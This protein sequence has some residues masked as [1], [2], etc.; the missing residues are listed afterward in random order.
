MLRRLE[1]RP[2]RC[3]N[4]D[5]SPDRRDPRSPLTIPSAR[6]RPGPEPVLPQPGVLPHTAAALGIQA[7]EALD[8]AH[9]L[10]IV[11]RDIK[12]ANLLLDV[13]GNLWITDFGLARL[14]DDAGLT[15][16]GDLLGTLRYMSPEQALAK[17]GYLDH[18]TDIYSLGATLYELLTLRP[19]IDGQ[20]RQEVLRKIAQDEPTPPRRLNPAIPRELETI[21]LKAMSKEPGSRY[22]TAQELAD[23][24]RAVP[25]AQADPGQAADAEWSGP[26]SGH[27]GTP[28]SW[29]VG[30]ILLA[31][32]VIGLAIGSTLLARKQLEVS[33]QRDRANESAGNRQRFKVPWPSGMPAWPARLSTR[34]SPRLPKNGWPTGPAWSLS[35][36]SSW[37]RRSDTTRHSREK[38][39]PIPRHANRSQSPYGA[40]VKFGCG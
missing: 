36:G 28:P 17:R 11:H 16:T 26:R 4:P 3:P 22:A 7:A 33:Q 14:Q 40:S 27:D 37:K 2:G 39:I 31:M 10:G 24:L 38:T 15:I 20:D 18:R 32:A 5:R 9:K 19:A 6:E 21:L 25:G 29:H 12:P 8:H 1:P 30:F 13:Q 23:D 35:S 34:C